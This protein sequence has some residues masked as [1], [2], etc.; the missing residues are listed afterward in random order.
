M[1]PTRNPYDFQVA[2]KWAPSAALLH[3]KTSNAG[4]PFALAH[5]STSKWPPS[6]HKKEDENT[7]I[8]DVTFMAGSGKKRKT[9]GP[10]RSGDNHGQHS[11][12]EKR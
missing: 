6:A 8:I 9:S 1:L 12:S 10:V 4:Q 11:S 5:F 7:I 2:S 3:A